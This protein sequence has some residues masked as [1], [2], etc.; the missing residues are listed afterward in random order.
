MPDATTSIQPGS[1]I[2]G[3]SVTQRGAAFSLPDPATD[4]HR[5]PLPTASRKGVQRA[6][7]AAQEA[8]SGW[9]QTP[10]R[11]RG[12]ILFGAADELDRYREP[13]VRQITLEMGKVL[14][15][16]FG[17]VDEAIF[18]LRFMAG[19]GARLAGETRPISNPRRLA[20]AERTP[21]GV[22]GVITPWNFPL[23][24]AVWKI[25]TALV[26][27]NAIVFNRRCRPQA[28]P[29]RSRTRCA[30]LACPQACSTSWPVPG[31]RPARRSPDTPT[32][33]C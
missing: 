21:V 8:Q 20:A 31:P 27:G 15:E 10:A 3:E 24:I 16:S 6:V 26:A 32:F 2:A 14:A 33:A 11:T 19:E 9:A 17:E 23:A 29:R 4:E 30:P 7:G 28:R 25:A 13:L 5:A 1:R 12:E 22:V 18:F